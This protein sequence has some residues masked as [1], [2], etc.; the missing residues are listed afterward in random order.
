MRRDPFFF[1]S[2]NIASL[3]TRS[4]PTR[5][6]RQFEI[7]FF[8]IFRTRVLRTRKTQNA[9]SS[10]RPAHIR[11]LCATVRIN[12]RFSFRCART[13]K[14]FYKRRRHRVI[15]P[16]KTRIKRRLTF[17]IRS[18]SLF[19]FCARRARANIVFP[20]AAFYRFDR[21]T[22]RGR[23]P[24]MTLQ[25]P[26]GRVSRPLHEWTM[27]VRYRTRH[28]GTRKT[29]YFFFFTPTRPFVTAYART[30]D[31]FGFYYIFF[32]STLIYI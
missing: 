1:S 9:F 11:P 26:R 14:I 7:S 28:I 16:L 29:L 30:K 8:S 19:S 25:L 6:A 10:G 2:Q 22:G 23:P 31:F 21:Q 12:S 20:S 27:R 17:I 5:T 18:F 3:I 15:S 24:P 13:V 32:S 4:V